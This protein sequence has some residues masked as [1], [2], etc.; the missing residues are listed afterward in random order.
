MAVHIAQKMRKI[1]ESPAGLPAYCIRKK[2][3]LAFTETRALHPRF[4][5]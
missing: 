3:S 4:Y 2:F 5:L 1:P